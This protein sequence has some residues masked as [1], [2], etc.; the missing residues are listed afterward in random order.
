MVQVRPTPRRRPRIWLAGAVMSAGAWSSYIPQVG[1][2]KARADR[3]GRAQIVTYRA[4]TDTYRA[5][6]DTYRAQTD[7]Y[8]AQT[9][10]YRA[11]TYTY[12]E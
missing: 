7:T 10:T 9:Y 2:Y 8:R 1:S 11:W 4:Q 12:R 3:Y 5:Q 6:T